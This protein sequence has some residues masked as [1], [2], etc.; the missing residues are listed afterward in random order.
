M[1]NDYITMN[2]T[3]NIELKMNLLWYTHVALT[4]EVISAA[5]FDTLNKNYKC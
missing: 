4:R 5:V 1:Y 3:R 2:D